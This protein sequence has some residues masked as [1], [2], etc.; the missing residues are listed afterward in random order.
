M[1]WIKVQGVLPFRCSI[2]RHIRHRPKA[3]PISQNQYKTSFLFHRLNLNKNDQDE[4]SLDVD[5]GSVECEHKSDE[6]SGKT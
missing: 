5:D 1:D 6:S 4:V 2:N 3:S